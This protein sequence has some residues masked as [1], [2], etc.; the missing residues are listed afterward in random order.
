MGVS[1]KH[2]LMIILRIAQHKTTHMS[3]R[4]PIQTPQMLLSGASEV[5]I[6]LPPSLLHTTM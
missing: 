1:T 4:V 6:T 5:G 3:K 2:E